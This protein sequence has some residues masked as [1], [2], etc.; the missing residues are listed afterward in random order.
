MRFPT[1]FA[2]RNK[3]VI[4]VVGLA[5]MVGVFFATFSAEALPVIGG[6]TVHQ[7]Y[8][9]EAGG[10]RSGDEVRVAGVK[11]GKVTAV[12]LEG[13]RVLVSFRTDGVALGTETT[14]AVKVKTLLG[15]KFL[16]L[17][18]QGGG[19][20]DAPIPLA[21][22]TTPYDVTAAFSD[23]A[24]TVGEIDTDQLAHS[25][26]TL[27][28]V[29]VTTPASVRGMVKG[30]TRLSR[31]ISQRDGELGRLFTA[32]SKVTDVVAARRD[33]IGKLID[34]GDALLT[35]LA[36]RRAAIHR[37]LTSTAELGR[38]VQGLVADNQATLRPALQQLDRVAG[39]L[40]RNQDHL[41]AALQKI[42]PYYRM[43]STAMGNGHW[44][45]SYVCGLFGPDDTPV[46]DNDVV[47]ECHPGGA[48]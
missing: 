30:L 10:I 17:D 22:T 7:A 18:P 6:G 33:E 27:A 40:R 16:A 28:R 42:G 8:F 31:T 3:V 41:D 19:A 44:V 2:E 14:A 34:D 20:L 47:R 11:V 26:D 29:F 43:L 9:A 37:M 21:R 36:D 15:Q 1:A 35:E 38:Q 39:I 46:L 4:A 25:L 5:L 12:E 24:T 32:T 45:D 48:R 23:L 13:K